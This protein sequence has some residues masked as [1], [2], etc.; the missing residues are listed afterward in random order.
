MSFEGLKA[1]FDK[2][3]GKFDGYL[4]CS[5]LD[6]TF[7]GGGDTIEVNSKAVKYSPGCPGEYFCFMPFCS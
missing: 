1:T 5:D 4:I 2:C 6:G 7:K 3:V